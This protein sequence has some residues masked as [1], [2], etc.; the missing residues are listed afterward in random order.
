M[1]AAWRAVSGY[2]GQT[3]TPD[4]RRGD[5]VTERKLS[6]DKLIGRRKVIDAAGTEW[7]FLSAV[8]PDMLQSSRHAPIARRSCGPGLCT[9]PGAL[10]NTT[11]SVVACFVPSVCAGF[12]R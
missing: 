11:A 2:V 6:S 3:P 9:F 1:S 7:L 5:G 10:R 4:V 12:L 8:R